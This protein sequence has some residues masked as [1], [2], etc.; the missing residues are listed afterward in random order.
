MAL[1]S[2]ANCIKGEERMRKSGEKKR[3]D[4]LVEEEAETKE[5]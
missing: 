5:G 3:T 4:L 2:R 1:D